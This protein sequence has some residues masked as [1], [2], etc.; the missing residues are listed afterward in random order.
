MKK[1][2]KEK[3]YLICDFDELDWV[4]DLSKDFDIACEL[5][6]CWS[7]WYKETY[8]LE[9]VFDKSK[10]NFEREYY[11]FTIK[12]KKWETV[13]ESDFEKNWIIR[14]QLLYI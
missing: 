11:K 13:N 7:K 8:L 4:L 3:L 2:N 5:F 1:T 9:L 10:Y 6:N 14:K 12:N